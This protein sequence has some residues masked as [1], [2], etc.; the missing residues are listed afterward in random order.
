MQE[1]KT[2]KISCGQWQMEQSQTQISNAKPI[3]KENSKCIF[4][5]SVFM[6]DVY[7]NGRVG[8][9][10]T[11]QATYAFLTS[12]TKFQMLCCV[13]IHLVGNYLWGFR[14]TWKTSNKNNKT[15]KKINYNYIQTIMM[16]ITLW[17]PYPSWNIITFHTFVYLLDVQLYPVTLRFNTLYTLMSQKL[18]S[19]MPMPNMLMVLSV[20]L[21]H[22]P[23]PPI[24]KQYKWR[25]APDHLTGLISPSDSGQVL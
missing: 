20:P 4:V 6:S 22:H 5:L 2:Y 1:N 3:N 12:G 11:P 13:W 10:I 24:S 14:V 21:K 16:N 23:V 8:T 17:H 9:F 18:R 7:T 15:N 25:N 19:K